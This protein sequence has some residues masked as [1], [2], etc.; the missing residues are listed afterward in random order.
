MPFQYV[1]FIVKFFVLNKTSN[2]PIQETYQSSTLWRACLRMIYSLNFFM[3]WSTF[4]CFNVLGVILSCIFFLFLDNIHIIGSTSIIHFLFGYIV[5]QLTFVGFV[6]QP[7][8]CST[9]STFCLPLGFFHLVDFCCLS[10]GIRVLGIL[11]E[12]PSFFKM[13]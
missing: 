9:W 13:H 8:K 11:F 10:N 2:H 5:S 3:C 4:A 12:F 7:C 6:V 1:G